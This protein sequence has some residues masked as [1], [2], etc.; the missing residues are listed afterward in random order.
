[1]LRR[2]GPRIAAFAGAAFLVGLV[3][4]IGKM[5]YDSRLPG[6]Y[7]VMDY[8]HADH[9]GGV[10]SVAHTAHEDPA[11]GLSVADLHGPR[12]G[13]PDARFEL[14][15]M[16]ATIRL[17]SGRAVEALTF[18]GSS[19]GPELRVKE[20]DLVEVTL[21]NDDVDQGVTIHWHGVDVPNAE[22]GVAG[23][24]QN[25]V[26]P[27]ERY[28]YRFRAEQVGTFWYHSHQVS[29]SEVRRG[30]F[31]AFVIE[32]QV[33]ATDTL[34]LTIVAHTF[35]G[36][37]TINAADELARRA[38][39]RGT[40]VRLR[41]INTDSAELRFTLGGTPYRVT[42]IDGTDLVGPTPLENATLDIGGG[43]RMDVAFTMPA[44]PVR[45]SIDSKTAG[46][47]FSTDGRASPASEA[48]GAAFDP[49]T[50][51]RHV[52]SPFD[53][54]T[55]FDRR[56]TFTI[57][58]KPGFYDGKPGLQWA[59]NG[60]IYP[61]VPMFVVEEGDLV[62]VTITNDTKAIHPMHLHG[63][64]VLVLRRDGEDASGSPWWVDTLNM[65]P[66]ERYVIAFRADNPG[67]W[68]DHCHNLRHA[69]DG[70][71]MHVAYAGVTTPFLVGDTSNNDP[72]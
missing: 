37:P 8:G 6:T 40:P 1:M 25:A 55:S 32:P 11:D 9:G 67:V 24:T 45:L 12:A 21:R 64:H 4:V 71:T 68:M 14:T 66:G 33:A 22:D 7:N 10:V 41:L 69:A 58:R 43:G 15:A 65:Q 35:D 57:T 20:G 53:A 28:T 36:V 13:V 34:D 16:G 50:Y 70:L 47:A 52:A 31:G 30:L 61:D 18:N 42:A 26:L 56:F 60:G 51:G 3:A 29:S 62:K 23:V 44:N 27:G 63:H 54:S 17:A 46:V 39:P 49:L 2:H 48:P 19:P 72:E 59:I 38:V 5:W